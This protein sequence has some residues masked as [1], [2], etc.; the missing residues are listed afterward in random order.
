MKKIIR[1][2]LLAAAAALM[3]ACATSI[4]QNRSYSA[5]VLKATSSQDNYMTVAVTTS[6]GDKLVESQF[7]DVLIDA[8][9]KHGFSVENRGG[10]HYRLEAVIEQLPGKKF[11]KAE[12]HAGKNLAIAL[13][14]VANMFVPRFYTV[15]T[16]FKVKFTVYR[17]NQLVVSE[18]VIIDDS[19]IVT[20]S[21]PSRPVKA[22]EAALRFWEAKRDES[23][24]KLFEKL[25]QST[26][27]VASL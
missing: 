5:P 23:I 12:P 15:S 2:A 4:P 20:V 8:A 3:S 26:V 6:T 14:P 21:G 18:N 13:I 9:A 24:A 27:I 25:S 11:W 22:T 16:S 17:D 10:T 1:I 7:N 19:N